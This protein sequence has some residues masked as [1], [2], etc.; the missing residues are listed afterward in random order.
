VIVPFNQSVVLYEA[1]RDASA[2]DHRRPP[3]AK[4]ADHRTFQFWVDGAASTRVALAT[5]AVTR[6]RPPRPRGRH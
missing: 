5:S 4:T 6:Q 2:A 3:G 1:L